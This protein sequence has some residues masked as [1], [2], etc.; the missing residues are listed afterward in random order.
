MLTII[1][2]A[3]T[4]LFFFEPCIFL[5]FTVLVF[6]ASIILSKIK[7]LHEE[8]FLA[9]F[10]Y[11]LSSTN[12]LSFLFLISS[13]LAFFFLILNVIPFFISFTDS[14]MSFILQLVINVFQCSILF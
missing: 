13:V 12:V 5:P 2:V 3:C 7:V 9:F 1:R 14:F 8:K 4:F 10:F 6:G 11:H